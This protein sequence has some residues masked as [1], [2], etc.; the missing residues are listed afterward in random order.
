MHTVYT[1][2]AALLIKAPLKSFRLRLDRA[3][4]DQ[5][6]LIQPRGRRI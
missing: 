3:A 1:I 2:L 4:A 6:G 5:I